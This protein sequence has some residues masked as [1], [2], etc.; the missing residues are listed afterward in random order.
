MLRKLEARG[1]IRESGRSEAP[2]RPILY[3]VTED[4]MDAFQLLS[5]DELPELPSFNEEE[6][7]DE[8]F[9]K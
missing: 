3:S 6:G 4:F 9:S 5:L 8:L 1:L 7:S 2:G